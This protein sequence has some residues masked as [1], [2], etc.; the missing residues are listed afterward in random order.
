MP[1]PLCLTDQR[2]ID[3]RDAGTARLARRQQLE[4][5]RD[6]AEP[7][8]PLKLYDTQDAVPEA[9]RANA[10]ETKDGKFAVVE[11]D[12]QLADAGKRALDAER[13]RA[14]DAEEARKAAEKERDDLKRTAD[15]KA[16]GI[17]EEELQ[18]IR[19]AEAAARKPIED[20][21]D[22]LAAENL[23]LKRDDKV[24]KLYL[25]NGGMSDRVEDAMDQLLKRTELGDA[26]GIVF[27]DEKG[28]VTADDAETFFKKFRTAKPWLFKGS[29]ASGSGAEGSNGSGGGGGGTSAKEALEQKRQELQGAL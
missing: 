20:E 21:R 25:D 19:D 8:M 18:K 3:R 15:A 26:D 7:T 29:G 13:K 22:R 9:Q 6:A 17:S 4:A 12:P 2:V 23:K 1:P 5:R 28:Q 14:R 10:I 27:K 24:Q 16:K 11:E